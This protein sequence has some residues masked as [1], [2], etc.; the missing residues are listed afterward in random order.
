MGFRAFEV[1]DKLP[2]LLRGLAAVHQ[3]KRQTIHMGLK[4]EKRNL[5]Y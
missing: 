4:E 3:W 5:W 1:K 2:F